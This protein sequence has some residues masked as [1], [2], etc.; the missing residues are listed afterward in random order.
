MEGT[1]RPGRPRLP[2]TGAARIPDLGGRLTFLFGLLHVLPRPWLWAYPVFATVAGLLFGLMRQGTESLWPA[3]V[4]HATVN[5]ANLLWLSSLAKS[6]PPDR[7]PALP[8]DAPA[9][10]P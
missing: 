3:V 7:P 9:A 1:E 2:F 5:V 4:A 6:A 8:P 10:L